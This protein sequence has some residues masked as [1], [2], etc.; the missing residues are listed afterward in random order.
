MT[1]IGFIGA[2]HIGGKVAEAAADAGFDVVVSGAR[3]PAALAP[4]VAQLGP[5][6][7]AATVEEAAAVGE[8][9][10][11]A[12]PVAA[13]S[14][15]PVE[16]LVGKVVI[17]TTNYNPSREGHI[18]EIDDG[19]STVSG[20]LQRRLP[21]SHVVKAFNMISAAQVPTDGTPKGTPNR[22][23][24]ALAGDD[25]GARKTVAEIYDSFGFDAVDAGPLSESWRF[26]RGQP[27]F[28]VQQNADELR[29]NLE[30]ARR[31]LST[32][33]VPSRGASPRR[34]SQTRGTKLPQCGR[35]FADL[36]ARQQGPEQAFQFL[37]HRTAGYGEL[38]PPGRCQ[39]EQGRPS[40]S[41]IRE[42]SAVSQG[43]KP[44]G[45]LARTAG[46]YAQPGGE[47]LHA[48]ILSLGYYGHGLE[49]NQGQAQLTAEPEVHRGFELGLDAAHVT[50]HSPQVGRRHRS[51]APA[52]ALPLIRAV[53]RVRGPR[54]Y[55]HGHPCRGACTT[56]RPCPHR[57]RS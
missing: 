30:R 8:I 44:V 17:N 36:C 50:E 46:R 16:P 10:V 48:A 53:T 13:F 38:L 19:S 22:R 51:S 45:Q 4:L 40:V 1:T 39:L 27:A 7:R 24:L 41:R 2:G 55:R 3:G 32:I 49:K 56:P 35:E 42:P 9:V 37:V 23:A 12:V 28:I 31:H 34:P 25:A 15:I 20:L 57:G 33:R 52:G 26:G 43:T 18:A 14:D 21:S 11:V 47:V 6:A 29:A 54:R 5:R